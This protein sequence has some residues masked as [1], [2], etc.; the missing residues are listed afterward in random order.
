[1]SKDPAAPSAPAVTDDHR[2]SQAL[3]RIDDANADDPNLTTLRGEDVPEALLYGQRMSAR[4]VL[5]CPDAS[6][7]LRLA[8]RAQHL[9]R[10]KLPRSAYPMDRAGYKEWRT[11]LG[12]LHAQWAGEILRGVGYGEETIERVGSLLRKKKLKVDADA[13]TLEDVACLVFLEHYLDDFAAKH[14]SE[15]VVD[16]LQKTWVKM[17]DAGHEA[18]L[19]L[20][21]SDEARRLVGEALAP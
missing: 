14:P 1:M 6:E 10:W 15:K 13:Q 8:A 17:S 4:L 5:F 11:E 9:C 20:P 16:I 12:R 3:A 19:R 7:P 21:L 18:A 2:F